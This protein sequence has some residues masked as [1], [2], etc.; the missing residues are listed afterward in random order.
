VVGRRAVRD[1]PADHLIDDEDL[2][3]PPGARTD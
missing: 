3:R 1:I 2:E